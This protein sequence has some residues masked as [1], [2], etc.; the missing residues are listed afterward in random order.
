MNLYNSLWWIAFI[1]GAVLTQKNYPGLDFLILGFLILLQEEDLKQFF[2]LSP[3]L[4]LLQESVSTFPFGSYLMWYFSAIV[5]IFLSKWLFEVEN[6]LFMFL[7]SSTLS[8]IHLGIFML[9]SRLQGI[10]Y[11]LENLMDISVIQALIM[12]LIWWVLVRLRPQQ[13][14]TTII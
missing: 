5:L 7:F 8:F 3:I 14:E 4:L 11:N 10:D 9:M 2:I 12:P 6:F 1:I 13:E